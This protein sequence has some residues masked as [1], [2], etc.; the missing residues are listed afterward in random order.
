MI[1]YEDIRTQTLASDSIEKSEN[2]ATKVNDESFPYN[3]TSIVLDRLSVPKRAKYLT[4]LSDQ[5]IIYRFRPFLPFII[6]PSVEEATL[7][8]PSAGFSTSTGIIATLSHAH[9][10]RHSARHSPL[11][12]GECI[13]SHL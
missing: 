3:E 1:A 13:L 8:I 5:T 11:T 7:E 2:D 9:S 12:E 4:P 10:D 6:H